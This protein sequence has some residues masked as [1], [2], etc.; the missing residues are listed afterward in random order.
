M[1]AQADMLTLCA[2]SVCQF[3]CRSGCRYVVPAASAAGFEAALEQQQGPN[4]LAALTGK[5]LYCSLPLPLLRELGV[6]R[7]LQMPGY[8]VLT[9]PVSAVLT[10]P[11]S[12]VLT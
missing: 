4:A 5:H 12:A 2:L 11:V 10:Y 9:Y 1:F 6:K 3:Q 8:A 7:F